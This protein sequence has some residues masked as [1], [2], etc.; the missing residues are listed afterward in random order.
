MEKN[1]FDPSVALLDEIKDQDLNVSGGAPASPTFI[2]CIT[3]T[4]TS[5]V[6]GNKGSVC[7]ATVECQNNC[8]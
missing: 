4:I 6:L 7:T 3:Y 1:L 5:Y 8:H 2:D